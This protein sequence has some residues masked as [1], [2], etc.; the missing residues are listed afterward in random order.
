MGLL[1]SQLQNRFLALWKSP[2]DHPLIV[3]HR[4]DS[5]RAPENTLEAA[6]LAWEAGAAAWE[7]DVRLT[8]DRV[9]IIPHDGS[10]LRT[11]DVALRLA[12]L[13]VD[14]LLPDDPP[15]MKR[16]FERSRPRAPAKD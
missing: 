9:P 8:R 14:G 10:L 12:E 13:G 15:G 1:R 16:S 11:T 2:R 4:G 3:A 6:R 5:F 7:L